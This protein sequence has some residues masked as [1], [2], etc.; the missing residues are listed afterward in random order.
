[1]AVIGGRIFSNHPKSMNGIYKDS[2]D[3]VSVIVPLGKNICGG[4]TVFYDVLKTS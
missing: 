4:E 2:R 1:M 3:L